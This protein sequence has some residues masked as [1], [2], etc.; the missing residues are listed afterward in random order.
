MHV[1]NGVCFK[2]PTMHGIPIDLLKQ[3]E[4]QTKRLFALPLDQKLRTVRSPEG[5]TGYGLARISAFFPKPMWSEGFSIM[6]SPLEDAC[7]LWPHHHKKFWYVYNACLAVAMGFDCLPR[8]V[9]TS[10]V[11]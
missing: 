6:V 11:K 2:S 3:L 10:W 9:Y 7:Q 8:L 1:S 5:I 4:L